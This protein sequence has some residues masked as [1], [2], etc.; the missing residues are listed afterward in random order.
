MMV[1]VEGSGASAIF[2]VLGI[3]L[4]EAASVLSV[5]EAVPDFAPSRCCLGKGEGMRQCDDVLADLADVLNNEQIGVSLEQALNLVAVLA[6][7]RWRQLP[8]LSR[9]LERKRRRIS[10]ATELH[11]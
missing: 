3:R 5:N 10:L 2:E 11:A 4:H 8:L 6:H 9:P 7:L 1:A